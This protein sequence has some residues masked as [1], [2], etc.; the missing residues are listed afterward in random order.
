[1]T[2]NAPVKF[3]DLLAAYEWVSSSPDDSEAFVS[4][5][6][7]NVHW[8]SSTM[9]LDDELPEDIEDGSIYVAVPNKHELNLGKNLALAFA[10]EQ[11]ADSYQTVENIFRQRGAYGRFKDLLERKG[12]LEAWYDYEAKATELALREWA[13]EEELSITAGSGQNAG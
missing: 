4:R 6:T 13:A 2:L 10:E 9:E 1:M 7:G 3:D 5:V 8:S 12:C 11:L